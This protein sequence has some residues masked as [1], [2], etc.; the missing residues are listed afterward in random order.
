[1]YITLKNPFNRCDLYV[2]AWLLYNMHGILYDP[3]IINNVLQAVL[4][5]LCWPAIVDLI[6]YGGR[7]NKLIISIVLLVGM[8]FVY[9]GIFFLLN[10]KKMHVPDYYYLQISLNSL[11]PVVYMYHLARMGYLTIERIRMYIVIFLIVA[12][13]CFFKAIDLR[14]NQEFTNNMGYMFLSVIPILMLFN[15]RP[16]LQYILLIILANYILLCMKRGAII[17]AVMCII[18]F[19]YTK[20]K[21]STRWMKCV[22]IILSAIV[23]WLIIQNVE[24]MLANS[25]YFLARIQATSEGD[26]SGRDRLYSEIV[27]SYLHDGNLLTMIIGSGANNTLKVAGNFAHQDWLETLSN[28]G[29]LGICILFNFYAVLL[30]YLMRYKKRGES[31]LFYAYACLAIICVMKSIFSMSIQNLDLPQ[32]M[33]MGYFAFDCRG[34]HIC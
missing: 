22:A 13:A 32:S 8:Y 15:K 33:L 31:Y 34:R 11:L 18:V 21:Y 4:I 26:S 20:L 17:I 2:G 3:G 30:H 1:M 6:N 25:D 10:V 7:R 9:G 23:V 27:N 24:N 5:L 29:L 28:N 14:E 12:F 16:L 19:L